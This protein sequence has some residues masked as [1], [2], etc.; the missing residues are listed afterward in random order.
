MEDSRSFADRPAVLARAFDF[1]S[2]TAD[3]PS[4]VDDQPDS[5][6]VADIRSLMNRDTAD[7]LD[8]CRKRFDDDRRCC[9]RTD[10]AVLEERLRLRKD[11]RWDS[12]SA[13][14]CFR[15]LVHRSRSRRKHQPTCSLQGCPCCFVLCI[16]FFFWC[17]LVRISVQSHET[18]QDD[19]RT[20][21]LAYRYR[22]NYLSYSFC[23]L[24]FGLSKDNSR[25]CRL[26]SKEL[27]KI[28]RVQKIKCLYKLKNVNIMNILN[29]IRKI[30][31]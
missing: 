27:C 14:R 15:S 12:R 16:F 21:F 13:S 7:I 17:K 10:K 22:S 3:I 28:I 4:P 24:K 1:E 5:S 11:S 29:V 8:C 31:I 18:L 30:F 2:D 25:K 6:T 20:K 9:S 26:H 23:S 19:S